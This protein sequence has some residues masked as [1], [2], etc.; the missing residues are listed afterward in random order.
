MQRSPP[1]PHSPS[2][3]TCPAMS[4]FWTQP[5]PESPG[6]SLLTQ[7]SALLQGLTWFSLCQ[8][9]D[10]VLDLPCPWTF[11]AQSPCR[12][13]VSFTGARFSDLCPAHHSGQPQPS[14]ASGNL[15]GHHPI[16]VI[17]SSAT[18]TPSTSVSSEKPVPVLHP[19]GSRCTLCLL[20]QLWAI[21]KNLGNMT[22]GSLCV[23]GKAT[24]ESFAHNATGS[25]NSEKQKLVQG[26]HSPIPH[27][28]K[29][30][31]VFNQHLHLQKA[32]ASSA[33]EPSSPIWAGHP[34]GQW[35]S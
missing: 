5:S 24:L 12:C 21:R 34:S 26:S 29:H 32:G 1:A 27:Y 3:G 23:L 8:G 9:S 2:P 13:S 25:L 14:R 35:P 19:A 31:P 20:L 11:C 17:T 22:G 18:P 10:P 16:P 7:I 15:Q 28:V 4:G 33:P 6:Q 30:Q